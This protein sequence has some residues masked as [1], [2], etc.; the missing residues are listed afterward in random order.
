MPTPSERKCRLDIRFTDEGCTVMG[1][2]VHEAV[3]YM[4]LDINIGEIHRRGFRGEITVKGYIDGNA[5][6]SDNRNDV[7]EKPQG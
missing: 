5:W 6:Q 3:Q 2:F 1:A 4:E 7:L